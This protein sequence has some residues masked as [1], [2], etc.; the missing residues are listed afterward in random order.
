MAAF[1]KIDR[2]FRNFGLYLFFSA[3]IL[4]TLEATSYLFLRSQGLLSDRYPYNQVV[5]GYYVF[6]NTPGSHFWNEVKES[7]SDPPTVVDGNGFISDNPILLEKPEGTIR[8]FLMGGSAVYGVGQFPPFA[9]VH[10]YH[11]GVLSF[12]LG[13]AGQLERFLQAQRP[14]LKFEV[15]NAAATDRMLH[16][17]ML[18]YLETISRYSPDLVINVDGY[19]DLFYGMMSGRPY[20]QM[21]ARLGN[22]IALL[23]QAHAYRPNMIQLAD[24]IY[25]K[26]F[27][28]AVDEQLKKQFFLKE[29]LDQEKYALTAYKKEEEG[30]IHSSQRFLQILDHYMAIL[31]SD[32]VDFI[33]AIQPLLYRQVNKQWSPIE[34]TM[35]RTVFGV[36]PNMPPSV[37]DRFILMSKYFFDHYL[38]EASQTRVEKRGFGFL[39]LNREIQSLPSDFELYVDYCHFTVPGSAKVASL[40]GQKVLERLP[41]PP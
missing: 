29:D 7:P 17:S 27:H 32:Q 4:V 19:N 34:D 40:L 8:I 41:P 6:K 24:L 22:Y 31:T 11:P 28:A 21:E 26:F 33:F 39:D 5:S 37:I 25:K 12:A 14:D 23:D 30:F 3:L 35:R 13:P 18:Y 1:A 10:P 16:Q 15:I 9:A 36:G 2:F 38:V 20:A